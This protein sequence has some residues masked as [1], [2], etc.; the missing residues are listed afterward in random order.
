MVSIPDWLNESDDKK[1]KNDEKRH[2]KC[3]YHKIKNDELNAL[4]M[5]LHIN[6]TALKPLKYSI[7][8]KI[9]DHFRS[10]WKINFQA[11]EFSRIAGYSK[12]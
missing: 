9:P 6:L 11:F 10:T 8:Y 5:L 2:S 7:F 1:K 3:V 4:T 12:L